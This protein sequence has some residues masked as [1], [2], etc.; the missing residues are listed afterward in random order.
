MES[1]LDTCNNVDDSQKHYAEQKKPD[2]KEYIQCV[3]PFMWRSGIG[4]INPW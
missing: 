3:I 4:K 1:T 2:M